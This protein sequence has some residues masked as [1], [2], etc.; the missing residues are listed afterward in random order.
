MNEDTYITDQAGNRF[1]VLYSKPGFVMCDRC[2][3]TLPADE[4]ETHVCDHWWEKP[5]DYDTLK[6][7]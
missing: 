7:Q 6:E 3:V 2:L 4:V 1:T 5:I